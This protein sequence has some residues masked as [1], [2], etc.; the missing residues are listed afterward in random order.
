MPCTSSPI[1]SMPVSV[2]VRADER[3][4]GIGAADIG[5]QGWGG[6]GHLGGLARPLLEGRKEFLAPVVNIVPAQPGE[7]AAMP[8]AALV[9]RRRKLAVESLLQV[10]DDS[11]AVVVGR[12]EAVE[13]PWEMVL[14]LPGK[15]SKVLPEGTEIDALFDRMGRAFLILGEPGSGKTITLLELARG[16]IFSG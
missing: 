9:E 15:T 12:P 10:G 4:S 13:H 3:K 7:H 8:L 2:A 11:F 14:E 1:S 5:D 16:E 6:A